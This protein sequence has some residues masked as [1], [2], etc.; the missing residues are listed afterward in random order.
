MLFVIKIKMFQSIKDLIDQI[1]VRILKFNN[2]FFRE[3][4]LR[5]FFSHISS[6]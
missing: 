5:H 3:F 1:Q 2:V 4:Y 6:R